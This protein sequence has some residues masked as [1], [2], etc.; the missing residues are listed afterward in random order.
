MT[1]NTRPHVFISYSRKDTEFVNRLEQALRVEGIL[2]WRDV[3]SIPGGTMWARR[4]PQGLRA[5]YA[6]LYVDTVDADVS[7]W[8]NKEFLFAH[9]LGL[10]I[11]PVRISTTE[12][13]FKTID[14]NPVLCDEDNFKIGLGKIIAQLATL[15]Q[16]P[17]ISGS[18]APSEPERQ[19]IETDLSID[20]ESLSELNFS[21]EIQDYA[22]WL[23]V[24]SKADLRDALYV[25][26]EASAHSAPKPEEDNPFGIGLDMDLGIGF[27]PLALERV[28]GDAFDKAGDSIDDA[29]VPVTEANRVVL[30]GEP[31]IGRAHV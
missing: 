20:S 15:P 26:L 5:S 14:L 16:K 19:E 30:L 23:L 18:I 28:R 10:P 9:S 22:R 27:D 11:I 25:S 24:K 29:R 13:F 6:M 1:K 7:D 8:C 12:F 2:T 31:E 21:A 3:H 17:I 4:I